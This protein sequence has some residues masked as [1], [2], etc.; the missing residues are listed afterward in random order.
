MADNQWLLNKSF[1]W[2]FSV[3]VNEGGVLG[4]LGEKKRGCFVG[5]MWK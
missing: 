2:D 3:L 5:I 4:K 1:L